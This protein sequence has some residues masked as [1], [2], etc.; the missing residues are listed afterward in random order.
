MQGSQHFEHGDFTLQ[1]LAF[2]R[3]AYTQYAQGGVPVFEECLYAGYPF[4]QDPQ[5]QVLYPPVVA[6]MQ[7][8]RA[9]GWPEYPLGALQW[10]VMGHVLLAALGMY[11][12]A[13]RALGSSIGSDRSA[14]VSRPAAVI[15]ALAFAFGGYLT[16]YPIL[17]TAILETAA[18]LPLIATA[19]H[20]VVFGHRW[21]AAIVTAA[22]LGAIA[23]T[24]GHPQTLMIAAYGLMVAFGVWCVRARVRPTSA[25]ARAAAV[26][27]LMVGLSAAQWL[28]SASFMLASTRANLGFDQ[29]AGGFSPR[30]VAMLAVSGVLVE[31]SAL[32]SGMTAFVLVIAAVTFARLHRPDV[33]LW[34]AIGAAALVLSFGGHAF[35][36]DLAYQFLPGYRQ[37]QSQARHAVLVSFSIASLAALGADALLRDGTARR[38]PQLRRAGVALG[39][40]ALAAAALAYVVGPGGMASNR[41]PAEVGSVAGRVALLSALLAVLAAW[42]LARARGPA[43]WLAA[44]LVAIVA[45]DVHAA[46]HGAS[47]Q[48][49]AEPFPATSLISPIREPSASEP[50]Q[51]RVNN[52]FGLPLNAACAAGLSEIAGGSPIVLKSYRDFLDRVPEDVYSRLL[53]VR[54]TVTW[55]GGMGTDNG[56]VIPHTRVGEGRL[57]DVNANVFRLD[58]EPASWPGVWVPQNVRAVADDDALYSR[59]ASADFAPFDEALV[60]G[61]ADMAASGAAGLEG[62]APGYRKIAAWASAPTVLVV[63]EAYHWNWIAQVNGVETRPV[64]VNGAM[65]GVPLAAGAS[66]VELSYRPIDLWVG[67]GVAGIAALVAAVAL[68]IGRRDERAI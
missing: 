48:A 56:R 45:A 31:W 60:L 20:G 39:L 27:A 22:T 5:A 7:L 62:A 54:Y 42:A 26:G 35:G 50:G 59:L 15:A 61:G 24:A 3:L 11:V 28:P 8:G 44:A 2:R 53:N 58:W 47:R 63:S 6:M 30:D 21:R 1:F 46:N 33:G 40:A 25:I 32:Y 68:F 12:F 17:Q 18:W 9:L 55:R 16:S 41:P 51:I 4:Q 64:R 23:L 57:Y 66:S 10:E 38:A 13:R 43:P 29:A 65:L 36:F 19:L 67:I 49:P 37:F 52:H 34:L 14:T